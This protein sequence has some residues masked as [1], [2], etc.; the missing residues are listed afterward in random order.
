MHCQEA[1]DDASG[2]RAGLWY[3]VD[4]TQARRQ[5][6]QSLRDKKPSDRASNTETTQVELSAPSVAQPFLAYFRIRKTP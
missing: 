1:D 5:V 2:H 3:E 4:D 6:A